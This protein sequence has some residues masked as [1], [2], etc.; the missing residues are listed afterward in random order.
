M[1]G[2]ILAAGF[3]TRFRPVTWTTPKP[4]VPVCNRPL[5]GYAAEALIEAGVRDLIVNLHHLPE[6]I[7]RYLSTAFGPHC[8]L[9]FSYEPEILGT[10][11][12]LRKVRGS[13]ERE[14]DFLLV[15]GDTIQ[16]PRLRELLHSRRAGD[17][18]A[19]L[20]LRHPPGD[21]RFT[22]VFFEDG[23][24]NGFG[25]G[26]GQALMFSGSHAISRRVFDYLPDRSF[27][28]IV[29]DV[30][31]P[32]VRDRQESLA[33][34]VDHELWFDIGTPMRY[35]QAARAIA[36]LMIG[37]RLEVPAGSRSDRASMSIL[38]DDAEIA[39]ELRDSVIGKESQVASGSVVRRS[40]IWDG[41]RIGRTCSVEDSVLD[42]GVSIPDGISVSNGLVSRISAALPADHGFRTWG[43]LVVAPI[44]P[45]RPPVVCIG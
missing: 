28:G 37:G 12:A 4:M 45:S 8:T 9:A 1:K 26:H 21:D 3:G 39:G 43:D 11:G 23:L 36:G 25:S 10:G 2:M 22:S 7:E 17:H 6:A 32:L 30:Y 5:I 14:E 35:L 41:C 18:L 13:L 34:V 29:E 20:T 31:K 33:G 27:S 19:A 42:H 44:D 15:N 24:V 16:R 40:V 38:A